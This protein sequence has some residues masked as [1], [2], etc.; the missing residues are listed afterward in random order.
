ML[1]GPRICLRAMRRSDLEVPHGPLY[2]DPD[3]FMLS[4]G[5]AYRPES[6]E[7]ALARFDKA[8]AEDPEP[9]FDPFIA[10]SLV[11]LSTTIPVGAVLGDAALW[12]VDSHTRSAH[13]G[14]NLLPAARGLGVGKEAVLL[15]ADYAFR[16]RGLNRLQCETYLDNAAM[17][18]VAE[19][20]GFQREGLRREVGWRDGSYVD[21]VILG[22]LASQWR[23]LR[24]AIGA[25]TEAA[26]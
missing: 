19:S 8:L 15:L 18:A 4:E 10:E 13:I 12:G 5:R 2:E 7:A 3:A 9:R 1:R 21:D 24:G 26:G 16:V 20:V 17:L 14:V 6:L 11:T 22:L 23:D 25:A